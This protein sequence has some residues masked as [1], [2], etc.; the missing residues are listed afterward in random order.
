M[1]FSLAKMFITKY[2]KDIDSKFV[3]EAAPPEERWK[4]FLPI[5]GG[6]FEGGGYH[7]GQDINPPET[8]HSRAIYCDETDSGPL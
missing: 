2:H 6:G 8:A 3:R 7:E 5:P 4:M 1:Y